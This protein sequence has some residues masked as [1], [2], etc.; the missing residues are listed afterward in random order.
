MTPGCQATARSS[1]EAASATDAGR[2]AVAL[3]SRPPPAADSFGPPARGSIDAGAHSQIFDPRVRSCFVGSNQKRRAHP[4][5]GLP[6]PPVVPSESQ[7][8]HDRIRERPTVSVRHG[9][10]VAHRRSRTRS[11]SAGSR[12][13]IS[14][15]NRPKRNDL[16]AVIELPPVTRWP[17]L[18]CGRSR[19]GERDRALRFVRY[20]Q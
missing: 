12:L 3:P 11:G 8:L 5:P 7:D 10:I 19:P 16:L 2:T 9:T 13:D 18:P 6:L 1:V 15:G 4:V 20:R 14:C 17:L